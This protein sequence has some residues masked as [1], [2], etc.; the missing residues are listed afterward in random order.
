MSERRHTY[1]Q[2]FSTSP[3]LKQKGADFNTNSLAL[4]YQILAISSKSPPTSQWP[5]LYTPPNDRALAHPQNLKPNGTPQNL[6]PNGV[7]SN[8]V[9]KAW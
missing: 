7:I 2:N 5:H 6:K 9:A 3:N 8:A 4:L 1:Y